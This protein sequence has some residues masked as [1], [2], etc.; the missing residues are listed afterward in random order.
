MC[1][2]ENSTVDLGYKKDA[3]RYWTRSGSRGR[4]RKYRPIES[5]QHKFRKV[6]SLT[7]LTRWKNETQSS[8]NKYDKLR[9][10]SLFV[11]NIFSE[12][13]D[14]GGMIHDIDLRKWALSGAQNINLANF[15]ASLTWLYNFK[16]KYKIKSRK[17]TTFKTKM[18]M[19]KEADIMEATTLFLRSR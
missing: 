6:S 13:R 3:V 16:V 9:L 12:N 10:V 5:V 1:P 19:S 2:T 18:S 17:V 11:W 14:K 15:K 4:K 7:Q 8:G